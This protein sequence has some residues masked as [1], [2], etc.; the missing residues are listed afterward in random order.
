MSNVP[1]GREEL[2]EIV[3]E[4]RE[5]EDEELAGKIEAIV[6]KR[7]FRK[8]TK[9]RSPVTSIQMD[10]VVAKRIMYI[11]RVYPEMS[12]QKIAEMVGVNPGRVS[13]AIAGKW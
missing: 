4:L 9:D 5:A 12:T 13:E 1:L 11:H 2:L 8:I 10:G 6:F 3:S 7:L